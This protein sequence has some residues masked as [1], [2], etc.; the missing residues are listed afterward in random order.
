GLLRDVASVP[1]AILSVDLTTGVR[2]V[3][4]G[5][6]FGA[7]PAFQEVTGLALDA[8][9]HRV[10][11]ADPATGALF[12]VDMTTGARTIVSADLPAVR[13]A[14]DGDRAIVL[15]RD[16]ARLLVAVDLASGVQTTI[17]GQDAG[18]VPSAPLQ[19][20]ALDTTHTTAYSIGFPGELFVI[21]LATG[22]RTVLHE[23]N[24]L[25]GVA[26]AVF[27][28]AGAR[29][30]AVSFPDRLAEYELATQ[31]YRAIDD[32]QLGSGA[33]PQ[34]P[35]AVVRIPDSRSLLV[36]DI[37]QL[38]RVDLD[39]ARRTSVVALDGAA[40]HAALDRAGRRVLV[41]GRIDLGLVGYDLASFAATALGGGATSIVVD[42]AQHRALVTDS[43]D[44][45]QAVDLSTGARTLISGLDFAFGEIW[46]PIRIAF[47]PASNH[48]FA[49]SDQFSDLFC[50]VVDV[51]LASGHRTCVTPVGVLHP[52][53]AIAIGNGALY[54]SSREPDGDRIVRV[55]L[56]TRQT[57]TIAGPDVGRG[58]ALSRIADLTVDDTGIITVL[59]SDFAEPM[60]LDPTTGDRVVLA[61]P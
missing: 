53:G 34:A 59:R 4:S 12:A 40:S 47:D 43:S 3:L 26:D 20:L 42:E 38:I 8:A 35:V 15:T 39:D 30:F 21:D 6:T 33:V 36:A 17:S 18:P 27:D 58:P 45:L 13:V 24:F 22:A 48:V 41:A 49:T 37:H 1:F 50:H 57:L 5:G 60:F 11:A 28:P 7:G 56:A 61:S 46:F 19:N 52:P 2:A 55:D 44:N 25:D 32:V 14:L 31:R 23:A 51:D 16:P 9:H 10:L 54:V 29:L